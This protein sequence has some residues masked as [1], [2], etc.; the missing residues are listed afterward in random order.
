MILS[1]KDAI[2]KSLQYGA[3]LVVGGTLA[4]AQVVAQTFPNNNVP[5]TIPPFPGAHEL[6]PLTF[7]PERLDGLSAK[8][9][10][11]HYQNNYR[12]AVRRLN[13]IEKELKNLPDDT[14]PYRYGALKREELIAINSSILHELY[15]GNLGG[16][17]KIKG[18]IEDLIHSS[19]GSNEAW[20]KDFGGKDFPEFL[21]FPFYS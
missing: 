4:P 11:S 17:G 18:K 3:A 7:N 21:Q 20:E 6:K 12:G 1:R 9:I 19:Y 10:Q 8:L 14:S 15:F 13:Q 5:G 2:L 16:D